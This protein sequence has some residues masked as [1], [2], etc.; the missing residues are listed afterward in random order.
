MSAPPRVESESCIDGLRGIKNRFLWLLML[1]EDLLAGKAE[2]EPGLWC[3]LRT[4]ISEISN[5]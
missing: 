4:Y 5:V 1:V 3:V 2:R